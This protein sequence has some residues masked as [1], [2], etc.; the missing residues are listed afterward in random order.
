MKVP[1]SPS[2]LGNPR[3]YDGAH[4]KGDAIEKRNFE[5]KRNNLGLVIRHFLIVGDGNGPSVI[6]LI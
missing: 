4:N 5:F 3:A 6:I 2:S 1:G